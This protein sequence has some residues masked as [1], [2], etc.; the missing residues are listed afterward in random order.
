MGELLIRDLE[1]DVTARL[2]GWAARHGRR[3]EEARDILRD[4]LRQEVL[5]ERDEKEQ[6]EG[7][8]GTEIAEMF[9]G[10]GIKEGDVQELH[11][12][13]IKNPFEE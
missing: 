9:R 3:V 10:L 13:K 4:G 6:P 7:G 1:D 11:G 2:E 5:P 8:L 12:E